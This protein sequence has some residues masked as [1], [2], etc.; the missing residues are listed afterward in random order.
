MISVNFDSLYKK[1]MLP[2]S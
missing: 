1:A 2:V